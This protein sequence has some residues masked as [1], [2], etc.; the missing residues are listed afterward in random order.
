MVA[1]TSPKAAPFKLAI[2]GRPNVGKSSLYN[3]LTRTNFAL[4]QDTPGVTR[5]WREGSAQLIDL[6]FQVL[7]TAGLE[8]A[9]SGTLAARM[10]EQTI[11]ALKHSDAAL[12]VVDGQAG[13]LPE[14]KSFAQLLRK[15]GKPVMLAV[16]KTESE[17]TNAVM[18]EAVRMGFGEPI[19]LSAVHGL[20]LTNFIISFLPS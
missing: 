13:I 1:K 11:A 12:L 4:V 8:N 3:R 19:R 17:K 16:N 14:D 7:D 6:Q 2:I 9:K 5:D 20:G 10:T 18:E 15:S